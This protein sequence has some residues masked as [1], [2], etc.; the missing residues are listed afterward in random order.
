LVFSLT[1]AKHNSLT[2]PKDNHEMPVV[3]SSATG[4]KGFQPCSRPYR[5]ALL[6]AIAQKDYVTAEELFQ[7]GHQL[8]W[9]L[10]PD[11][12]SQYRHKLLPASTIPAAQFAALKNLSGDRITEN[13]VNQQCGIPGTRTRAR[14][15]AFVGPQLPVVKRAM[16]NMQRVQQ[17]SYDA[18]D[19]NGFPVNG[20]KG[21]A[22]YAPSPFQQHISDRA[23]D[24]YTPDN[25]QHD[26][27]GSSGKCRNDGT[28]NAGLQ[29]INGVCVIPENQRQCPSFQYDVELKDL[30]TGNAFV[31]RSPSRYRKRKVRKYSAVANQWFD[32]CEPDENHTSARWLGLDASL[33]KYIG[34]PNV[35]FV[36]VDEWQ[37]MRNNN[38]YPE[39]I[40]PATNAPYLSVP[41]SNTRI[42]KIGSAFSP[43]IHQG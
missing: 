39:R 12:P 14:P 17:A 28:C 30:A 15:S 32:T 11:N 3:Y 2:K 20:F 22:L 33:R 25:P 7:Q 36:S 31:V 38:Q 42:Y 40:D 1:K 43:Q 4:D 35:S 37:R 8:V 23:Q 6:R 19:R 10:D 9:Q 29:C 5:Q 26:V 18:A 16:S 21:M 34:F 13:V 27:G 24:F 41:V